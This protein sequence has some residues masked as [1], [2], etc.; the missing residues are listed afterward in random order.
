M[1]DIGQLRDK[2][3]KI[4]EKIVEL[5]IQRND[6]AKHIGEIKH[7][8]KIPIRDPEVEN[9]VI[10]RYRKI[11]EGSSLPEDVAESVCRMLISCSM[12]IQSAIVK[13]RC[14]KNVT[15]IGGNGKMGKWMRRY[16]EGLGATVNI[17]DVSA[18]KLED[19]K[20]S[21]IVVISVPISSV[22]SVLGDVDALCGDKVL[23]FDISSIKSPFSSELKN[24]AIRRKVCSVHPMFGPSA[25]SI[26]GRN[27]VICDCGCKEAVCEVLKLFDGANTIVT[28]VERHDELMAYVLGL[29]HASNIVLFTALRK[30]GIPFRELRDAA[31]STFRGCIATCIPLSEENASLYHEIQRLNV[32][33]TEMWDIYE[34]VVKEVKEASLSHDGEEFKEIMERGKEY[35]KGH[36]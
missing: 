24:M 13:K 16:L 10:E 8:L 22:G 31:S 33:T 27:V 1:D 5:M 26:A 9:A 2:I 6:T 21:D 18:G 12:D 4:D 30:S 14:A 32:N 28:N 17:I 36:L 7:R 15:I 3:R 35:L 25:S 19:M 11:S 34:N 29:A 20:G 23:I